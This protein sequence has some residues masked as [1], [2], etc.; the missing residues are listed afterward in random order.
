MENFQ[1]IS[2]SKHTFPSPAALSKGTH[3]IAA[4]EYDY[5]FAIMNICTRET[6]SKRIMFIQS[7][8]LYPN[9]DLRA[10]KGAMTWITMNH[11]WINCISRNS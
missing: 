3:I 4:N 7:G 8:K 10:L 6:D 11:S 2:S 1:H 5:D 9:Y